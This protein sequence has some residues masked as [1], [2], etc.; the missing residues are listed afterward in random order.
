LLPE[1]REGPCSKPEFRIF[2]EIVSLASLPTEIVQKI[3]HECHDIQSVVNLSTTSK[4]FRSAYNGSQKLVILEN[5]L[6]RQFGP[7]HDAVQVAT[8]NATQPAHIS[9]YP[10]MSFALAEQILK[11]GYVAQKWVQHC[12]Q[13]FWRNEWAT[14]RRLLNASEAYRFRRA[15]YRLWLYDKA[16]HNS[17]YIESNPRY[18]VSGGQDDERLIFLRRFPSTDV[19]ELEEIH[20]MLEEMLKEDLCPSNADIQRRASDAWPDQALLYFG[21]YESYVGNQLYMTP[22]QKVA[23]TLR[24]RRDWVSES[25]GNE[26]VRNSIVADIMKLEP[27]KLLY[28]RDT[29][30]NKA[31]RVAFLSDQDRDFHQSPAKL[32]S[33]INR[34]WLDRSGHSLETEFFGR[35]YILDPSPDHAKLHAEPSGDTKLS[36]AAPLVMLPSIDSDSD[37]AEDRANMGIFDDDEDGDDTTDVTSEEDANINRESV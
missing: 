31:E 37:R 26:G 21:M 16:F 20:V 19:M 29:L 24:S 9:R 36:H 12:P 7:L 6:E 4:R 28:F 13:L 35:R 10:A 11:I 17:D 15:T 18:P 8:Y 25:W 22:L 23:H 5:I 32:Q 30:K 27:D 2:P 3:Y 14:D 1:K 33:A 34:I